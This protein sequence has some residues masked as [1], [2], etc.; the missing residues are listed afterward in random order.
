MTVR[1]SVLAL[2]IVTPSFAQLSEGKKGHEITRL[3][4]TAFS[5]LPRDLVRELQRRGCTIPQTSADKRGNVIKGTFAKPG[6][7]D[8]AVLCSAKGS[9]TM[10]VFW[11]GSASDLAK[12]NETADD[13]SGEFKVFIRSVDRTFVTYLFRK[14]GGL[15]LPIVDHDGIESTESIGPAL[16][17]FYEGQW[18]GVNEGPQLNILGAAPGAV[19]GGVVAVPRR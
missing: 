14:F 8:W 11:N 15:N 19:S 13:S 10:L 2:L 4:P 3:P 17:Y 18:Q 16:L 9:T 12:L 1:P 6:K 7:T 5:E